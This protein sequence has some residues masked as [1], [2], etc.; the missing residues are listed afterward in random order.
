M[1]YSYVYSNITRDTIFKIVHYCTILCKRNHI[2]LDLVPAVVYQVNMALADG[3]ISP[4]DIETDNRGII[5]NITSVSIEPNGQ[6]I[7]GF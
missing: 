7:C 1:D 6:V 3:K 2:P 5:V 4:I